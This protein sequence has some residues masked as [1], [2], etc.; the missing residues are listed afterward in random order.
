MVANTSVA[1][2][3]C[4]VLAGVTIVVHHQTGDPVLIGYWCLGASV[5]A[6]CVVCFVAGRRYVKNPLAPGRILCIV[7]AYNER[8]E[9]L[10]GTV[11]ALLRQ[12]VSVDIVVID[13]GSQIPVVPSVTHP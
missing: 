3:I 1:G 9:G 11:Q 12:T 6:A 10:R 13:D 4:A 5:I 2:L 8:P 7:P